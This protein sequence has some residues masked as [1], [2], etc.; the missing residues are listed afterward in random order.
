MKRVKWKLVATVVDGVR[1][2]VAPQGVEEKVGDL[3]KVEVVRGG[4]V[5]FPSVALR[6]IQ[7]KTYSV[8]GFPFHNGDKRSLLTPLSQ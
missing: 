5:S 7:G 6:R 3:T 4:M 1:V 8:V 2:V